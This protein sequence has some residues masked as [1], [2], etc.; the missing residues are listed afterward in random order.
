MDTSPSLLQ[1]LSGSDADTSWRT[2]FDLY[3]P[4]IERWLKRHFVGD[5]DCQDLAQE[6]L[7]VVSRRLKDF[8]HNQRTGAFRNWL[9]QI[10]VNCLRDFWRKQRITP[11]GAG[12]S[13]FQATLQELEDSTSN[14]SQVWDREHDAFVTA[15]LLKQIQPSFEPRTWTAFQRVVLDG[16]SADEAAAELGITTNAVFIAKSRVLSKLRQ[17]ARG[18]LDELDPPQ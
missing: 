14:L 9:R 12:G 17:E 18:F 13:D 2:F 11:K 4:L 1:R 15:A 16:V 8:E 3:A 10:T 6:V 7:I 5:T